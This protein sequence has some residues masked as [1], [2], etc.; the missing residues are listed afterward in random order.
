MGC[1]RS[2]TNLLYDTLLSAGGF[3]VYRG[4]VPI[5]KML[6]P[7]FGTLDNVENRKKILDVWLRSKGFR[8]SGLEA[9]LVREKVLNRCKNGGDFMRITMDEI[10]RQQRASRW[11]LYDADTVLHV[12]EVKADIPEAIFVHIVRDGRDI[13]LSLKKMEGF[14]PFPWDRR[15]RGLLETAIYWQWVVRRGR[16]YG[17][18]IPADYIE[19]HY[20]ELIASPHGTLKRLGEFIDHDL[21]YDRIRQSALGSIKR[22]NSSFLEES[23]DL[24]DVPAGRWKKKMSAGE[25]AELESVIGECLQEFGYELSLPQ[26]KR[27]A[28]MKERCL[29]RFY[30]TL[31]DLKFLLKHNTPLGRFSDISALEL[32][33]TADA[34]I[35]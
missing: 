10:T 19:I 9:D 30:P 35:Q 12:P 24:Q 21:D 27:R 23:S 7:R 34:T 2:G 6:I 11:A 33:S 29:G 16:E 13:A 14:R 4:Y 31:L 28:G 26:H 3:A 15:Q 25:V 32:D 18:I 20:E 22:S 5:Y 8:R 17:R 1:H